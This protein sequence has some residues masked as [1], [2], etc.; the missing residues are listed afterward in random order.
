MVGRTK[1]S[2]KVVITPELRTGEQWAS[3]LEA[4]VDLVLAKE[5]PDRLR[6]AWAGLDG[7]WY[8]LCPE[9]LEVMADAIERQN[10]RL[11]EEQQIGFVD[12]RSGRAFGKPRVALASGPA[13]HP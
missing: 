4:Y 3:A 12:R 8:R 9:H 13:G 11:S 10:Q 5:R 7:S 2:A 1:S 6:L